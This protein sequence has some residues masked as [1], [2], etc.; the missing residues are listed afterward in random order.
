MVLL[1]VGSHYGVFTLAALHYGGPTARVW[2][3]DPSPRCQKLLAANLR[4]AGEADRAV[5]IRAA[6]GATDGQLRM[7]STGANSHD[8]FIASTEER[9]DAVRVPQLTLG[10][11]AT[12]IGTQVTHLKVDVEGFE[13]AVIAG[14]LE[15]LRT[16]RPVLFLELHG[17]ML[18]AAGKDP[19]TVLQDLAA[20][21]Y[22]RFELAGR[23]VELS[24]LAQ[25]GLARV[26]CLPGEA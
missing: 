22:R 10:S 5:L 11:L 15:F 20:C 25:V 2:A 9:P 3:V 13:D 6:V 23:S 24:E 17:D 18:R 14:G 26:V 21:G 19:R 4:L 16:V 8:F 7:L 12:K 1:D